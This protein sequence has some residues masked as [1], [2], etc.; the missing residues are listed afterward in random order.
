MKFVN[1][2]ARVTW[3]LVC[4]NIV[5]YQRIKR[6]F[7]LNDDSIEDLR[8]QLVQIKRVAIDQDGEYLI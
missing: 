3:L 4:E 8:R 2:L 1:V 6:D 5:S 7:G